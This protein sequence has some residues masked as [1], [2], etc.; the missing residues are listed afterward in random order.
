MGA[1]PGEGGSGT[2]T[3]AE[4]RPPITSEQ[5]LRE[6]SRNSLVWY[7]CIFITV[8]RGHFVVE[9]GAPEATRPPHSCMVS[10]RWQLCPPSLY[11]L[12]CPVGAEVTIGGWTVTFLQ[13][14]RDG[15]SAPACTLSRPC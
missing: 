4:I 6:I 3:P 1:P 7:V 2:A 15:T 14:E 10:A 12:P 9:D 8:S 11:L 5:K 13:K